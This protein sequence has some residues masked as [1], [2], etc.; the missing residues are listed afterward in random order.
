MSAP[1]SLVQ[2]VAAVAREVAGP[3]R[4]P[5]HVD[6]ETPLTDGFWFDSADLFAL[7]LACEARFGVSFAD[8]DF[9]PATFATL[10]S[11]A[12]RVHARHRGGDA[13]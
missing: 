8:E 9:S 2:E 11:L 7:V 3:G 12:D 6:R 5:S 10:G 13:A 4:Q 1:D